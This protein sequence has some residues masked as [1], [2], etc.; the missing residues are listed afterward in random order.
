MKVI[1]DTNIWI[2]MLMGFQ[3]HFFRDL[4][5]SRIFE[6]FICDEIIQEVHSV[7]F[8]DKF[9]NRIDDTNR[10]RLN[11]LFSKACKHAIITKSA[12]TQI[13]DSKDIY[14]LSFAESIKADYLVSGDKDLL[15]LKHHEATKIVSLSEFKIILDSVI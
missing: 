4:F 10:N 11:A 2:T 12:D 13:R 6:V 14:L 7:S 9:K 3:E 5:K 8:R 1:F 15:V